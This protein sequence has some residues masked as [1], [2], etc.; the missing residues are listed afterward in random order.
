MRDQAGP[1]FEV[2]PYPLKGA[3]GHPQVGLGRGIRI[4]ARAI[5][6]L[7]ESLPGLVATSGKATGLELTRQA[8]IQVSQGRDPDELGHRTTH[9]LGNSF[10]IICSRFTEGID[11]HEP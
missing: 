7:M 4:P 1:L 5:Q 6:E 9:G 2:S 11:P 3:P 8:S 10:G